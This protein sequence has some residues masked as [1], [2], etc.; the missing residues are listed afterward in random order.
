MGHHALKFFAF[1]TSAPWVTYRVGL[2]P[3]RRSCIDG[4]GAGDHHRGRYTVPAM[5]SS[6]TLQ[7]AVRQ[8]HRGSVPRGCRDALGQL[9]ATPAQP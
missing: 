3:T 1:S 2:H 6:T 5:Q 8:R 4:I 7:T 9:Q